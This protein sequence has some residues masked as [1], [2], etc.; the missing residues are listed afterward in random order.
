MVAN[1]AALRRGT[2]DLLLLLEG[3]LL[4]GGHPVPSPATRIVAQ[5]SASVSANG[6]LPSYLDSVG[7]EDGVGLGRR[8]LMAARG[9]SR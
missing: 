8:S 3:A 4:V 1:V 2:R 5:A 7:E 9:Q 6:P